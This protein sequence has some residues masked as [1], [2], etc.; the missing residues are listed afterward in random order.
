VGLRDRLKD[1]AKA[2]LGRPP[3]PAARPASAARPA[4]GGLLPPRD[5]EWVAVGWGDRVREGGASTFP[6]PDGE[7]G[8]GRVVAVFR[9]EGRL[10][11][12]DN[13]CRHEDGPVGEGTVTG[14]HV[15]CPYHDWEY[16]FTTGACLSTPDA[17]LATFAVRERDG[18][19]W[20]GRQLTEG[21]K[22]RGGEHNDG[23]ETITR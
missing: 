7:H 9:R 17:R 10:Y 3:A 18:A 20:I 21:T 1:T 6:L 12:T 15:R 14:C 11:A 22:A 8:K 4:Q 5:G 19:V 2:I 23:L 16:D 13:A